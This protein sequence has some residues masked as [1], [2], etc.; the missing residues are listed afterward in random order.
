MVHFSQIFLLSLVLFYNVTSNQCPY[1]NPKSDCLNGTG[2]LQELCGI[3]DQ[4]FAWYTGNTYDEI[5][6]VWYDQGG[7]CRNIDSNF[8][9]NTITTYNDFNDES[10]IT[11]ASTTRI[12]FPYDVLPGCINM[13]AYIVYFNTIIEQHDTLQHIHSQLYI[14]PCFPLF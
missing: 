4:A 1:D 11:G 5:E 9:T 12:H 8:I 2:T 6:N 14:L 10:Y 13:I 3:A 7:F